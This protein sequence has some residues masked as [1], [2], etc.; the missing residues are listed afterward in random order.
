MKLKQLALIS[1]GL[2]AATA[3]FAQQKA[4]DLIKT[5]QG[6]YKVISWNVGRIKANVDGQFNK[7]EV[8]KAAT[9]IQALA[10]AGLGA[11]YAPGTEKGVGYHET[12]AKPEIFDPNNKKIGEV[13]G[14]FG[15]EANELAKVAA[16]G[17][18]AAVKVQ[19]GKLQQTC[20][21]CHDDFRQEDHHH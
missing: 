5:R 16:T 6:A 15:K 3:S 12:A 21:A 14:N 1:L 19:L 9:A 20:K 10:N 7:D 11:L 13:A 8:L 17:N 18:K 2:M 4:E